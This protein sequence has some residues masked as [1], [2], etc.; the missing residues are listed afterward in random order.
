MPNRKPGAARSIPK[1]KVHS[2]QGRCPLQ[3]AAALSARPR[4][5]AANNPTRQSRT[6]SRK[7]GNRRY[8]TISALIDQLA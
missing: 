8:I 6:S 2:H 3:A 4:A 5:T 7:A 1:S